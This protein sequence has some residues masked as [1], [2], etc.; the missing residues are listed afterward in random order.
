MSD[1]SSSSDSDDNDVDEAEDDEDVDKD[2]PPAEETPIIPEIP[3]EDSPHFDHG[4]A[5]VPPADESKKEAATV[6]VGGDEKIPFDRSPARHVAADDVL[7]SGGPVPTQ[8]R[9]HENNS[10]KEAATVFGKK[11][12]SAERGEEKKII[13]ESRDQDKKK[14]GDASSSDSENT[15][16]GSDKPPSTLTDTRTYQYHGDYTWNKEKSA[17]IGYCIN[18]VKHGIAATDGTLTSLD[19]KTTALEDYYYLDDN[20]DH[21]YVTFAI[22]VSGAGL[23]RRRLFQSSLAS[24]SNEATH[25]FADVSRVS[26]HS[27]EKPPA[28]LVEKAKTARDEWLAGRL[29][30][31]MFMHART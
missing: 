28:V 4:P 3:P 29:K 26:G 31:Y 20:K 5:Q 6:D 14:T 24:M 13:I 2:D 21:L 27:D 9:L 19:C 11:T 23:Y 8:D 7:P 15:S 12:N 10:S 1:I 16:S 25:S 22:T 30:V 17:Y 18:K